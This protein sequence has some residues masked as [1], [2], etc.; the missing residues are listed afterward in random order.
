MK[1]RIGGE[2][3]RSESNRRQIPPSNAK[4]CISAA[5]ADVNKSMEALTFRAANRKANHQMAFVV[6]SISLSLPPVVSH[7]FDLRRHQKTA[8]RL[9]TPRHQYSIQLIAVHPHITYRHTPEVN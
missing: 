5:S 4:S 6:E 7:K 8:D 1:R 3:R 9:L 2:M